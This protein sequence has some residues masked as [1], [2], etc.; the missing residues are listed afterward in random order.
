MGDM[1]FRAHL[2]ANYADAQ[3]AF[4]SEF[5]D[6]SPTGKLVQSVAVKTDSSFIVNGSIALAGI[7]MNNGSTSATLSLWSRNLLDE[8]HIYR[9]SAANRGTIGDY[10]NLNPP[11]TVGV[12]LRVKY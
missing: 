7:N 10:G 5:A 3:Y 4:Q 6:V 9:I 12:E 1:T 11:R 2:D 8:T